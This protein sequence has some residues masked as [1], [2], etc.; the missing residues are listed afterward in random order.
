[1]IH[2]TIPKSVPTHAADIEF[3]AE[4]LAGCF[5]SPSSP[6]DTAYIEDVCQALDALLD[7]KASTARNDYLQDTTLASFIHDVMRKRAISD[8]K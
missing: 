8:L 5:Y 1:M 7:A 3:A 2:V 6:P 4:R